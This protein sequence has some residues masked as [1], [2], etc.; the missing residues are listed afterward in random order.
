MRTVLVTGAAGFI[1]SHVCD[2]LLAEDNR[3][4]GIDNLSAGKKGNLA[5]ARKHGKQFALHVVDMRSEDLRPILLRENPEVVMHLAAQSS[6]SASVADPVHDASLNVM[7]LLNVLEGAAAAGTR[8]VVF[9]ASGGTLYGSPR[10]LPVAEAA[11]RN[12][13]RVS[14]YGITKAVALEYLS[15]YR[16]HRGLQSTALALSNVYGPRQD[17]FGE[18]GVVAIF[19]AHMLAGGAPTI[20][21]GGEQTRDYVFVKDVAEAFWRAADRADGS[22]LNIGTGVETSVNEI[23]GL[24]ARITGFRGGSNDGPWREGDIP[25]TS[26]DVRAAAADLGWKPKTKL[27]RGL[28]ETVEALRR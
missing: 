24:L 5:E 27:E 9:A 8:K 15:F 11:R 26:L 19:G 13:G 25:R 12:L 23:F 18:A 21:G 3:V 1:G 2:R 14:P 20:F 6:V 28:R 16:R 22:L 4:V 7:G 17:P 10:K